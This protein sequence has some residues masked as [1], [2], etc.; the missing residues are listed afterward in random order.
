MRSGA[1]YGC[2]GDVMTGDVPLV[3]ATAPRALPAF[4]AF[5]ASAPWKIIDA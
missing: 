1:G 3:A 2:I 4:E 5:V